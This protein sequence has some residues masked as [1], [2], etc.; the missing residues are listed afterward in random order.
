MKKKKFLFF[1][2]LI[3]LALWGR[4]CW[5]TLVNYW[6]TFLIIALLKIKFLLRFFFFL[7]WKFQDFVDPLLTARGSRRLEFFWFLRFFVCFKWY[8]IFMFYILETRVFFWVNLFCF[9]EVYIYL[10]TLL[11]TVYNYLKS[12]FFLLLFFFLRYCFVTV[13][14]WAKR[15][16]FLCFF[17]A[18]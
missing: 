5:I 3:C 1:I 12:M 8:G 4:A 18:G 2:L 16:C 6:Y 11:V 14:F 15:I 9:F 13:C 10:D 17:V 7:F